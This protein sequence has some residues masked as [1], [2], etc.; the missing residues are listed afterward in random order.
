M[1]R[2]LILFLG[3]LLLP[4]VAQASPPD[5]FGYGPRT[6]GMANTG[7][8][9]ATNYEATFHNPA[10]LAGQTR[11]GFTLGMQGG[12]FQ[13]EIDGEKWDIDGYQGTTLGFHIGLPFGGVLEDVFV[14]GAGFYT[15]TATVLRTDILFPEVPNF[16]LLARTQSV[17]VMLGLG[18][19]LHRL[20]PGLRIGVGVSTLAN[21]G[22]RLLVG[23]DAAN[24]FFSQTETQLLAGFYPS[25]GLQYENERF[26]LGLVYRSEVR[27]DIDLVI[28]AE[29]LLP[30]DLELPEIT[31]TATPQYDPHTLA[32]EAAYRP[33]DAWMIALQAQWRRWSA[34]EG[35]VGKTTGSS[36][37]PPAPDFHDTITPRL[38]VEWQGKHRRTTGQLRGGYAFEPTPAPTA[39]MAPLRD[40]NGDPVMRAGEPVLR[41]R[42]Y[43]DNHRHVLSLGGTVIWETSGGAALQFDLFAQLHLLQERTHGI[44]SDAE[45]AG[46][47]VSNMVTS[48]FVGVA[49]WGLTFEW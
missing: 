23:L 46:D 38:G 35:S 14:I 26:A 36:N 17:H 41:P 37:L 42:R 6:Q 4:A 29:N 11:S 39:R 47:G 48:G 30:G 10:G 9:F 12:G 5:V 45:V 34:F 2:A 32:L 1:R 15:P 7:V 22:G 3:G 16:L 27:S 33:T 21:I 44:P 8:A 24:Q 43:L 20:L 25:V 31:I 18:I 28:R 13:L 40:S 19:S 49:G